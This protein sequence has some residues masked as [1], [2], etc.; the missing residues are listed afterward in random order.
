MTSAQ[1]DRVVELLQRIERRHCHQN[2]GHDR[3]LREA[4]TWQDVEEALQIIRHGKRQES[5]A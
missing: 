3:L 5:A 2:T 4:A 1:K